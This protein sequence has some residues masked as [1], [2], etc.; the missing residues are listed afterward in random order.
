MNKETKLIKDIKWLFITL[1]IIISLPLD[2]GARIASIETLRKLVIGSEYIIVG[3]VSKT[4]DTI[5]VKPRRYDKVANIIVLEKLQGNII[6]DTI[7]IPFN[8]GVICPAPALFFDST[9]VIA[10]VRKVNDKYYSN[11]FE[12]AAI[13][14]KEDEIEIYKARIIELQK[15]LQ[16]KN[17]DKQNLEFVEW[18]IKCI[19]NDITYFEGAFEMSSE[20]DF[21]FNDKKDRCEYIKSVLTKKQ[22][23]RIKAVLL[24]HK[25][26]SGFASE[27]LDLIYKGNEKEIDSMILNNLLIIDK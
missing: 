22:K 26:V 1:A 8:T 13:T 11:G 5:S 24:K 25:K 3:Y 9:F 23:K 14:L 12:H 18:F 4:Y 2:L 21:K 20:S 6:E 10:F 19:E 17:Q 16:T 15:I 27:L 7:T